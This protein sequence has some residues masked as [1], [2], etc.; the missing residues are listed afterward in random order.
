[1]EFKFRG[2]QEY[3]TKAVDAVIALFEGQGSIEAGVAFERSLGFIG[4][5]NRM[6]LTEDELLRNL[7]LVQQ[8]AGLTRSNQL[9]FIEQTIDTVTGGGT[10]RFPNFSVEM[11]TGTGK[12]YVYIRTALELNRR[13]GL[14]KFIVV[15]PSVAVREGV[16]K[17]LKL[18]R[19]ICAPSMTTCPTATRFTTRKALA[20]VASSAHANGGNC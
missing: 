10:A 19:I 14:R 15:V 5:P 13:Y 16:I 9:E 6:D 12:T 4:S 1:M 3:Q 18:P 17:S 8:E 2:D 7:R 11:E 20:R